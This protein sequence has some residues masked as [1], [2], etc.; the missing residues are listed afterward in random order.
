[1]KYKLVETFASINGEGLEAGKAAFFIRFAGCNLD[2]SYC[3]TLWANQ[4]GIACELVTKADLK[5]LIEASGILRVTIT[6]GEPLL[7]PQ[8]TD[9]LDTLFE[10][11]GLRVE[12]ETN[13]SVALDELIAYR[14]KTQANITFTLDYK[15][16]SSQMEARMHQA[17]YNL[18]DRRD[19]VKFVAGS[20]LDL[21]RAAQIIDEYNLDS[22]TNVILSPVFGQIDSQ[23]MVKFLLDSGY[24]N[25]KMQL[26]M[27]KYIWA[28]DQKGV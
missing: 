12:F 15:L 28:P 5:D 20:L 14:D 13:G 27:H 21:N 26:Q 25:A 1:M 19:S 17:N 18:V 23:E 8:L 7:Q 4:P 2:C 16:P 3:D 6:G 24:H 9:L 22:R 11:K 10:I